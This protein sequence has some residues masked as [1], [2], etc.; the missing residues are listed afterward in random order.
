MNFLKQLLTR[1]FSASPEQVSQVALEWAGEREVLPSSLGSAELRDLFADEVRA[2]AVFSA[3][4]TSAWYLQEVKDAVDLALSGGYEN[5]VPMM[6]LRLKEALARLGY[7]PETGFPGDEGLEIPAAKPGSLQDLSSDRRINLILDTQISLARG[8]S[9]KMRG[10][11]PERRRRW[12]AWELVRVYSRET[13]RGENHTI[14]WAER[15]ARLGGPA[16]PGGRFVA[17]KDDPIW[18]ALGD[19]TFYQD[20]L[21]VDHPPFAFRS[22]MRWVEIG[23]AEAEALGL[24]SPAGGAAVSRP[25]APPSPS[26]ALPRPEQSLKGLDPALREAL[27]ARILAKRASKPDHVRFDDLLTRELAKAHDAYGPNP[28]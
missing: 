3:R 12:P 24:L 22:G 7:T 25:V 6:R 28:N 14:G 19:P 15:W 18:R 20:A 17:L 26:E 1:L 11:D 13:P 27:M 21:A 10:L 16:I 23:R 8:A 9:Q 2:R 5:D 4:T